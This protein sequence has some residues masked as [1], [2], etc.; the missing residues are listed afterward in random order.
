MGRELLLLRK[1]KTWQD[2]LVYAQ[3]QKVI[4]LPAIKAI[5]LKI[6]YYEALVNSYNINRKIK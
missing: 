6:K 1:L 4:F 3:N 2:T 5:K